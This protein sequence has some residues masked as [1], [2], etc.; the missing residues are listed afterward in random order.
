MEA[1]AH[2]MEGTGTRKPAIN[3]C[4]SALFAVF[5][6]FNLKQKYGLPHD[7]WYSCPYDGDCLSY[8]SATS[9]S[10]NIGAG[11]GT[12]NDCDACA[13]TPISRGIRASTTTSKGR[14]RCT[15]VVQDFA[16]KAALATDGTPMLPWLP[17]LYY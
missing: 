7:N 2:G 11:S 16:S 8:P 13:E 17:F 4:L 14:L 6:G 15:R 3:P 5:A 10:W 1:L 12:L 9:V